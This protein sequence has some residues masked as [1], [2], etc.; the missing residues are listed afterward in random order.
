MVYIF[1][2]GS[3]KSTN[4]T[5]KALFKQS[6]NSQ[7]SVLCYHSSHIS[8]GVLPPAT[9]RYLPERGQRYLFVL[10]LR[11]VVESTVPLWLLYAVLNFLY[12]SAA[13]AQLIV[14]CKHCRELTHVLS[15]SDFEPVVYSPSSHVLRGQCFSSG[16]WIR[17][18]DLRLMRPA[19]WTTSLLRNRNCDV[20]LIVATINFLTAK[21]YQIA[22]HPML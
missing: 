19:G 2:P 20:I 15:W 22:E 5:T 12:L 1:I 6:I 14:Y 8:V 3:H 4:S 17:T 10:L 11:I 21:H 7:D 18:R 16:A 9:T 13:I